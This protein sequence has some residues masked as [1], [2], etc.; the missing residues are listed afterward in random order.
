MPPTTR[1]SSLLQDTA[2][3]QQR[4]AVRHALASQVDANEAPQSRA[5]QQ[6]FLAGLIGQIE[7][8]LHEVHAQHALQPNGRAPV[9]GLGVMGLNHA[10]QLSP[11]NQLLHLEELV[12]ARGLSVLLVLLVVVRCHGEGLLLHAVLSARGVP[13]VD[14]F[15]V[16]IGLQ[17]ENA[18]P[19][20]AFVRI[21]RVKAK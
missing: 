9:A 12:A 8:V 1:P 20:S 13:A 16:A 15:S 17:A 6:R 4:R 10:A 7:P 18:S 21:T 19:L 2:E 14:L 3:V 5:V 11:R